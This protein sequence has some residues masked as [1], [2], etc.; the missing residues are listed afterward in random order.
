MGAIINILRKYQSRFDFV[1]FK[2]LYMKKIKPTV[3]AQMDLICVQVF[4]GGSR[5]LKWG[6]NFCNNVREIKYYF[7]I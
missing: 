7:N 2:M 6:V 5:I 1:L 4:K 3:N